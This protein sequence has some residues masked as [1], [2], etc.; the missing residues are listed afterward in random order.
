MQSA[1]VFDLDGV[2]YKGAD[3]I[4]GVA[5]EITRLQKTVKVLFLTNNATKSRA[6]YISHL[7]TFGIRA[8]PDEV[9]TSSF[10]VAHYIAE[11]YGKGKSVFVVGESGLKDELVLEAGAKLADGAGADIVACGLD[12]HI[13]YAKLEAGLQ[14]L[15]EGAAFILAN[16]DPTWPKERGVAPGSGAIAA[17]LIFASGRQPDAIIGKPSNYLINKLLEMHKIKPKDATFVGDRLEIDIR[18]ANAVGMKSVLVLT[19]IAKEKD[20]AHAPASDKP[21][22]VIRSA[23]EV[24]KALGI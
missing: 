4:P 24:G 1:I 11:K 22:I 19:G 2:V 20:I 17:S 3:G 8:S 16:N 6:D 12:R 9:M 10:G 7:A 5:A 23:A 21:A 14:N 13:N 15:V 18:M